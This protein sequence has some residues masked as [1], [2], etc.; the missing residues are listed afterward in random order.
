[1]NNVLAKA[2]AFNEALQP[3]FKEYTAQV[4]KNAQTLANA[5]VQQGIE[6]I[7]GG[8]ENHIVLLNCLKSFGI[9]GKQAQTA[10]EKA[11]MSVNRNTIPNETRSPFDP[12]GLRIGTP[13]MTTRG[14]KEAE[15]EIVANLITKILREPENEALQ[16]TVREEVK[17]ICLQHPLP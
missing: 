16:N 7:T 10:L 9:G 14:F 6:I 2:V 1:M 11:G 13:A 4:L 12:S 3:S 17:T 5:F 15:F 8:T